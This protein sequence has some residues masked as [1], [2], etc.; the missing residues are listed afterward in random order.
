[1][2]YVNHAIQHYNIVI[3]AVQHHNALNVRATNLYCKT[4]TALV[5]EDLTHNMMIQQRNVHVKI[6]TIKRTEYAVV[7]AQ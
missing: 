1:M 4:E 6:N 3:L 7:V 2:E 5:K